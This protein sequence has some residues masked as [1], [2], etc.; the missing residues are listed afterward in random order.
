MLQ[1]VIYCLLPNSLESQQIGIF[2]AEMKIWPFAI[3]KAIPLTNT[4][5][6]PLFKSN[7][8]DIKLSNNISPTG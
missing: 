8:Q 3:S 1:S 6:A 4:P 7:E 2:S 5:E